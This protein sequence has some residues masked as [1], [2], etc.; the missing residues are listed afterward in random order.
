MKRRYLAI[1][2]LSVLALCIGIVGKWPVKLIYNPTESAPKGFYLIVNSAIQKGDYVLADIPEMA[3]KLAARRQYLPR[4]VPILKPVLAMSGEHICVKNHQL[5]IN[6]KH[7]A[8]LLEK[9]SRGRILESWR[10][11]RSLAEGEFFLLSTYSPVSYDSRYFGP[12]TRKMITG[13][14]VPVWVFD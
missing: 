14:A 2:I 10:G 5:F 13:K 1:T 8:R 6:G 7:M 4:K 12:V 3:R 9:D 11:C